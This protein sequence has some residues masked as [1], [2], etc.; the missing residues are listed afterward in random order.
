MKAVRHD[1]SVGKVRVSLGTSGEHRGQH[2]SLVLQGCDT[3]G[4]ARNEGLNWE[5]A[6]V[7][8]VLDPERGLPRSRQNG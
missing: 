8:A 2:P 7:P 4:R 1:Q 6:V 5:L 3:L